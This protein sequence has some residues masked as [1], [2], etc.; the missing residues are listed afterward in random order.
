MLIILVLCS[1]SFVR[2]AIYN[3][4]IH[5]V[6]WKNDIPESIPKFKYGILDKES[7]SKITDEGSISYMLSYIFV[8][9]PDIDAYEKD[10]EE[11]G[12][13]VS[14][15]AG[16]GKYGVM[17]EPKDT[18]QDSSQDSAHEDS[19]RY[20]SVSV[21]FVPSDGTCLVSI[22]VDNPEKASHIPAITGYSH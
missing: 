13:T 14:T 19:F 10:L 20:P 22:T 8:I 17:G 16:N 2:V 12:F 7:S 9:R 6:Y 18:S 21:V 11:A 3:P 15:S 4:V 5:V 1:C